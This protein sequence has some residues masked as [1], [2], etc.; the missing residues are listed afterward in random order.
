MK[1]E[2]FKYV[3]DF[4]SLER[5]P[6]ASSLLILMEVGLDFLRKEFKAMKLFML[7]MFIIVLGKQ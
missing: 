3:E 7:L 2:E 5:G 6:K 1:F 4:E